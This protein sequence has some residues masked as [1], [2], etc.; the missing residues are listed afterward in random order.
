MTPPT[1]Q[2]LSLEK[3]EGENWEMFVGKSRGIEFLTARGGPM[4]K[5]DMRHK[6]SGLDL[7]FALAAKRKH[8]RRM[9]NRTFSRYRIHWCNPEAAL[10]RAKAA[11]MNKNRALR[12]LSWGLFMD[13]SHSQPARNQILMPSNTGK[14]LQ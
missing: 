8:A 12:S 1:L 2:F 4:R 13:Q 3:R 6:D 7:L 9:P 14:C 10:A 11:T 5:D